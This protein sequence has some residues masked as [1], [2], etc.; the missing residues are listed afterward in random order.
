L[1]R[2]LHVGFVIQVHQR[3]VEGYSKVYSSIPT[4]AQAWPKSGLPHD[5]CTGPA[6]DRLPQRQRL[7]LAARPLQLTKGGP[8]RAAPPRRLSRTRRRRGRTRYR[9][10]S[11]FSACSAYTRCPGAA[12]PSAIRA[13]MMRD[14]AYESQIDG[15]RRKNTTRSKRV[16]RSPS[17]ARPRPDQPTRGIRLLV[18][19]LDVDQS[20]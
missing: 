10:R 8:S 12:A 2:N 7:L 14:L 20:T 5:T 17:P 6:R 11:A 3:L 13:A 15:R 18:A 16:G 1:V 9:R 4:R 19:L